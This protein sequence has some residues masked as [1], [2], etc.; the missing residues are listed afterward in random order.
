MAQG[1][2]LPKRWPLDIRPEN[3]DDSTNKDARL[4]NAY[5][6]KKADGVVE[7]YKRPGLDQYATTIAGNGA[8]VFNWLGNIYRV[9]GGSI[10]KDDVLLG[11]VNSAGGVYR[12]DQTLGATPRLVLGNGIKAYYTDGTTLTE[13]TDGDFPTSFV[14][15]WGYLN[16]T[17]YVMRP[18]AGIQGD[19]INTPADWDPLNVIIAQIEPDKGVALSKQLVYIIALKQW[20]VEVFY[21][22]ANATGSPLGRV[23]GA[24]VSW[25]CASQDSVRQLD[26]DLLWA[27]TTRFS[28]YQ[29]AMMKDLKAKIV[30]TDPVERLLLHPDTSE[31][32]YSW[33][34]RVGGHRFY[35]LT[36]VANNL[37][38]VYDASEDRWAQ[39][40]DADGNY[41]PIVDCTY[42][43]DGN[44]IVQHATN[45]KLY[46]LDP[47]YF[48][49]DG[50][51]IQVD[52]YTVNFDGGVRNMKTNERMVF[53]G[54]QVAGS[55]LQVR[56]NDWDYDS[57]RWTNFRDVDLSQKLPY[58]ENNGS[59]RRRAMHLRHR[60]NTALRLQA[61]DLELLL[62]PK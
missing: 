62:G 6:E 38:L 40:T 57:K 34:F 20:S 61:I 15:G 48:D 25:G 53:V 18:D 58:L 42:D 44:R 56:T 3:R 26:G 30:S 31:G 12:F 46:K 29:V 47:D 10:Y 17:S 55:V 36:L 16:G 37:T 27:S 22:A 52:A 7:L 41:F 9:Q 43:S 54:D 28:A 50:E 1:F 11:A 39:W 35:V 59:F 60:C 4:V 13:I 21:D 51:L 19:E 33:A 45:G 49:D 23:E 32:V 24:K 8:G 14:K 2:E 5:I